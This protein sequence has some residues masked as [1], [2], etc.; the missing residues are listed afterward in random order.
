MTAFGNDLV[1]PSV[2]GDVSVRAVDDDGL[3]LSG[4]DELVLDVLFGEQRVWSLHAR[5]DSEPA[6]HATFEPAAGPS[7]RIA[8]WPASLVPR[9]RGRARVRVRDHLEG[10][11]LFD[12]QLRFAGVEDPVDLRDEQGV[13]LAV[14]AKGS[15]TNSMETRSGD[16][17]GPLLTAAREVLALLAAEGVEGFAAY[18][19]LL[20]AIRTGHLIGHDYDVDLAYLS[21][22]QSPAEAIAES[23]RLE[24]SVRA[25][26]YPTS[27]YGWLS[28]RID[29]PGSGANDPWLDVFGSMIIDG[30]LALM[31][32]VWTPYDRDLV[33]PTGT[34]L[35]EGVELPC[36]ADPQAWLEATYGP[37]WRVP[38][39]AFHF[40]KEPG[41]QR[42]LN[43]WFRGLRRNCK[44][45][46]IDHQQEVADAASPPSAFARWVR[47][48]EP[49]AVEIVDLGCGTGADVAWYATTGAH[50]IGLDYSR[51]G[52]AVAAARA[53]DA[54][55][56]VDLERVNLNDLRSVLVTGARL[57]RR[58]GPRVLTARLLVDALPA[59]ARELLWRL[60]RMATRSGGVLYLEIAAARDPRH[61]ELGRRQHL[62]TLTGPRLIEEIEQHGGRV[63]HRSSTASPPES[64][65]PDTNR[66]VVT[67]S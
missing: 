12:R 56:E 67:W 52:L 40:P 48:S 42:R 39:P 23:F 59:P 19:T 38:D 53:R 47:D 58:P 36:P 4:E 37:G 25:A 46:E 30:N 65:M 35:L 6:S 21:Q 14:N 29:L 9:L 18:G 60:S 7:Q 50:A 55:V 62:K 16:F 33:L 49:E 44:V 17:V 51:P 10:T 57:T 31:G 64:A 22:R 15:L 20:G 13:P 54:G 1:G 28:F 43:G 2:T 3:H 41:G 11:V 66:M 8:A 32:E 24:R 63:T 5:R 34:C 61:R 45:W 27:R 26:G